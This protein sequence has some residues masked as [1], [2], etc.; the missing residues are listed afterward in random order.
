MSQKKWKINIID[1]IAVVLI[2]AVVVFLAVKLGGRAVE[3]D[4]ET[5]SIRYTL[6]CEDQPTAAYEAAKKYLPSS[7]MASGSL[8]DAQVTA[9]EAVPS[10]MMDGNG[11]WV[12]DPNHV[13]IT[14]TVEGN[15]ER[16]SVL[17]PSIGAQEIRIGKEIILKTEYLEFNPA[18][19]IDVVY[20]E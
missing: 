6:L 17:V 2:L 7:I 18:V 4:S 12:E 13:D 3:S 14:F 9:A 19:V 15:V 11:N 20:G 8:Y 5:V 1:I 10:L 16:G